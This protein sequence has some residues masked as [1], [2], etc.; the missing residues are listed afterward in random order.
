TL[1]QEGSRTIDYY[2]TEPA[3]S[4]I[5][6][7]ATIT[8]T[9]TCPEGT[10]TATASSS[11][12]IKG[13]E[14]QISGKV[15]DILTKDPIGSATVYVGGKIATTTVS[16]SYTITGLAP[17][18]YILT[19]ESLGYYPATRNISIASNSTQNIG[20][21]SLS[22]NIPANTWRMGSPPVNPP[23]KTTVSGNAISVGKDLGLIDQLGGLELRTYRWNPDAPEDS[24]YSK[25][26]RPSIIN[27]GCSYWFK[28]YGNSVNLQVNGVANSST[29]TINL[30]PGWNQIGNPFNFMVRK[31]DILIGTQTLT[32]NLWG[33][34]D[35]E[36]LSSE[37]ILP[38]KGYFV[39]TDSPCTLSIPPVPYDNSSISCL[40][41]L[42]ENQYLWSINLTAQS[43]IYFDREKLIGIGK[44]GKEE[45][46]H[47]PPI[48]WTDKFVRLVI[49]GRYDK[50]IRSQ[51]ADSNVWNISITS[52]TGE[53]ITLSWLD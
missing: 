23:D 17:G 6:N 35:T 14:Y 19:V 51:I 42:N 28:S 46:G 16:G 12:Y 5:T 2:I 41:I 39:Y 36:Y 53:P 26:V 8:G 13:Q 25:Y 33:W 31:S 30:S 18:E 38:W 9:S 4:T 45:I 3:S 10:I 15:W 11:T 29:Q 27:T 40:S 22:R 7:Y 43:G 32:G 34:T 47:K 52:T 24:L 50:E 1:N 20:L 48:P 44:N 21:C 37:A 49:S